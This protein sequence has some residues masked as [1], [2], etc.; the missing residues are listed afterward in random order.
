MEEII[1]EFRVKLLFTQNKLILIEISFTKNRKL[2]FQHQ[3]KEDRINN[4]CIRKYGY[5]YC[6]IYFRGMRL[7][8]HNL[9][10]N[11]LF[12]FIKLKNVIFLYYLLI[13]E[14]LTRTQ[15]ERT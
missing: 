14:N 1:S 5:F 13:I 15:N 9:K 6:K 3:I 8:F 4:V 2:S 10:P 12:I 11:I 7:Y